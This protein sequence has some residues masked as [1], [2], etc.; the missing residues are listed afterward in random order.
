MV[1]PV[2]SINKAIGVLA[3]TASYVLVSPSS[4]Q[5]N[6]LDDFALLDSKGQFH[7]FTRYRDMAAMLLFINQDK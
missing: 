5:T 1:V 6:Q 2:V 3:I 7:Q 4:A